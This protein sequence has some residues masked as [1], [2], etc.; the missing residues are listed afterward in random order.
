MSKNNFITDYDR[1][2]VLEDGREYYGYGFGASCD[3]VC[4]LVFNTSMV[5]YQEIISDP[6]NCYQA[7]VMTYPLI[8]NYGIADDDFE[9]CVP[10]IGGLIVRDYND[11]PSNF[12]YTRTLSEVMEESGVPGIYGFDTR[13]ITK[14]IRDNGSCK[15]LFTSADTPIESALEMIKTTEIPHDAV[16]KLSTRKRWYSR[17]HNPRFNVVAIDCGVN[18]NAIK[19]LKDC[20]CNVTVVPWN[21][22]AEEIDS[23]HP[24]AVYVS[25]GP[26]DP[27]E[28]PETVETIKALIGKYPM[29]GI[30]LG[31]ELICLAFGAATYKMKLG[32]RGSNHPIKCLS[33]GKISFA[34]QNHGYAVNAESLSGTALSVTHIDALDDTVEGVQ[35]PK[36]R[37]FS[38]QYQPNYSE[39]FSKLVN[40]INESR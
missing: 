14:S 5:G 13:E 30:S 16:S 2:I 18:L 4:E 9:R 19:S 28:L 24:D 12:S 20:G 6:A 8:G 21:T 36:E 23:I 1:K 39:F 29:C 11:H 31:H 17:T 26:G 35:C 3:R 40:L 7:V 15:V 33:S 37:V 10:V 32:H 25:G 38:V 22:T 34:T 27:A